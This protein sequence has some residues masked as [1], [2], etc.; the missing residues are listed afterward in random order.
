MR[1]VSKP[2]PT[3]EIPADRRRREL[4][5]AAYEV[6][7]EKGLEGLR[8]RDIA[9]RASVNIS[10]LHYYFGTKEALLE[11]VVQ[12]VAERFA[13]ESDRRAPA[14][15]TLRQHFERAIATFE[16][17]P[18][19]AIVLQELALRAQRDSAT[20]DAFRPIFKL[21]NLQVEGLIEA[22][23]SA[24]RIRPD[25]EADEMA[26]VVTSFI[27]GAMTQLGVN[28]RALD[29]RALSRQLERLI[30]GDTP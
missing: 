30:N 7:A 2:A 13:G 27:I 23:L 3:A 19:L 16:A 10:T 11:A 24:G 12:F 8:T 29:F 17:S 21:W 15:Q 22:E 28:P 6:I 26:L 25:V 20:R 14:D 4:L 9:R 5:T 18:D 1:R